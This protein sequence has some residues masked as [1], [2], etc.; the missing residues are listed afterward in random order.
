MAYWLASIYGIRGI[1][2]AQ[3]LSN[4]L[5]GI[6]ALFWYRSIFKQLRS[7]YSPA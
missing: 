6:V 1:F 4:I 7:E 3:V 2:I 5:A